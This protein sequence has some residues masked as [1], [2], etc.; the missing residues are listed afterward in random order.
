MGLEIP[1]VSASE[2]WRWQTRHSLGVLGS[3]RGVVGAVS[4]QS[5][6]ARD[7]QPTARALLGLLSLA[8]GSLATVFDDVRRESLRL[9]SHLSGRE[10][11]GD[12]KRCC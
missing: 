6:R 11:R 12:F 2:G 9:E 3:L 1:S 10:R 5:R 8:Q 4:R 7:L